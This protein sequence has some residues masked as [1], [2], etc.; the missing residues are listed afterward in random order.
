MEWF[1]GR[2]LHRVDRFQVNL[3]PWY[4]HA[5]YPVFSSPNCLPLPTVGLVYWP[6]YFPANISEG[7]DA[8]HKRS[9]WQN[10]LQPGA[11]KLESCSFLRGRSDSPDL[12]VC[13]SSKHQQHH[14]NDCHGDGGNAAC[15][16]EKTQKRQWGQLRDFTVC[17]THP[18]LL[19]EEKA[20]HLTILIRTRKP[21]I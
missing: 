10:S 11:S 17:N 8:H 15:E 1:Q 20:I 12:Q 5:I 6:H 19:W 16:G 4:H 2:R 21:K 18:C 7:W 3:D 13:R 9:P 14:S